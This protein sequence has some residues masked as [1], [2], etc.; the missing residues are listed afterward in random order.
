MSGW[1]EGFVPGVDQVACLLYSRDLSLWVP[2]GTW[3]S[4]FHSAV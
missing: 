2:L 4:I 3:A 1:G